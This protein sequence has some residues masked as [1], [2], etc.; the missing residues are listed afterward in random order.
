MSTEKTTLTDQMQSAAGFLSGKARAAFTACHFLLAAGSTIAIFYL[1]MSLVQPL[2]LHIYL[3]GFIGWL[4]AQVYYRAVEDYL[5]HALLYAWAYIL[6]SKD[7]ADKVTDN[8]KRAG[9]SSVFLSIILCSL[10]L[11]LSLAINPDLASGI[12]YE[13]DSTAEINQATAVQ[14]SYDKDVEILR[15]NVT[16]AEE[17]DARAITDAEARGAAKILAAKKSQ[18][19]EMYRLYQAGNKWAEGKLKS[20]I[21]QAERWAANE[22]ATA[23]SGA[24]LPAAEQALNDY[25]QNSGSAR[26]QIAVT[27]SSVVASRHNQYLSTLGR[28]NYTLLGTVIFIM[29]IYILS[30]RQ[31][32]VMCLETGEEID[33]DDGEGV[34]EVVRKR[35]SDFNHRA[36]AYLR[37]HTNRLEMA[38]ASLPAPTPSPAPLPEPKPAVPVPAPIPEPKE[39]AP[40]PSPA[41]LPEPKPAPTRKQTGKKELEISLDTDKTEITVFIDGKEYSASAAADKVRKWYHRWK[42]AELSGSKRTASNNRQKFEDAHAVMSSHF[43]FEASA[44]GQTISITLK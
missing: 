9:R 15:E 4:A 32:V 43:N 41:P 2:G 39:A 3:A 22:V 14:S 29:F 19:A 20:A 34:Q 24:T 27:T 18:G 44:D 30:A 36:A 16:K 7:E 37:K 1:V 26:D 21:A 10:T 17:R 23:R 8:L 35:L 28:R 33:P 31:L 38:A 40:T 42:V 11:G 25:L 6:A 13:K 5:R 12:T